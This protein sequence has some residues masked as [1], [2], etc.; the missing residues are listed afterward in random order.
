MSLRQKDY[1]IAVLAIGGLFAAMA[2][3]V[4][5]AVMLLAALGLYNIWWRCPH[6]GKFLGRKHELHC[7]YCGKAV[8]RTAKYSKKDQEES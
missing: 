7:R 6:C 5:G 8:D 2:N 1:I 4:V 3:G